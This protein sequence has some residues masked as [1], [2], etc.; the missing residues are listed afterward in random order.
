[1][2]VL[3]RRTSAQDPEQIVVLKRQWLALTH[4]WGVGIEEDRASISMVS[5]ASRNES[6]FPSSAQCNRDPPETQP[7]LNRF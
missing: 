2:L 7:S 4:G 5:S 3:L 1:M 6:R